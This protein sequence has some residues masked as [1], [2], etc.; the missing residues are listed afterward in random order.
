MLEQRHFTT[1]YVNDPE[2]IANSRD[3]DGL[4]PRRARTTEA[5]VTCEFRSKVFDNPTTYGLAVSVKP[6]ETQS[7]NLSTSMTSSVPFFDGLLKNR[8]APPASD[9][10]VVT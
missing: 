4:P 7:C 3:A 1:L 8:D 5:A 2:D 6:S 9:E 10:V